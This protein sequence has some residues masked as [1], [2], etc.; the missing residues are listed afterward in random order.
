MT[1]AAPVGVA[2]GAQEARERP[3][4]APVVGDEL[5]HPP[6]QADRVLRRAERLF[7][8]QRP[9]AEQIE[10]ER[11]V[12]ALDAQVEEPAQVVASIGLAQ[13]AI[14]RLHGEVVGLVLLD[15]LPVRLHRLVDATHLAGEHLGELRAEH[16]ELL[17]PPALDASGVLLLLALLRRRGCPRGPRAAR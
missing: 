7:L 11:R 17:A 9:L 13:D 15:E 6:V 16:A 8:E 12:R 10:L 14:E 1:S 2:L 3:Q 4:R 5:E